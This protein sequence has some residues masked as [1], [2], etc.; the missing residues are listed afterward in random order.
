MVDVPQPFATDEEA[1]LLGWLAFFRGT[2]RRKAAGLSP[3]ELIRQSTPPSRLS[4]LGIVRHLSEMERVYIHFALRGGEL[5]LRYCRDDPEADMD[6]LE[7]ADCDP[8]IAAW[9]EDCQRSDTLL[10]VSDLDDSAP[11]NGLSVRWNVMKLIGE[12]ARHAGHVDLLRE[13]IDG[14]TGE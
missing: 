5:D 4:L 7:T 12:Y 2:I 6:G 1:L 13:C 14:V 10:G 3:E 11:G 8:S 9:A